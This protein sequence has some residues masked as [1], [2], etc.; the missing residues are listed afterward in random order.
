M[1]KYKQDR[2]LFFSSLWPATKESIHAF[3][4]R[5]TA[6]KK[7]KLKNKQNLGVQLADEDED[8]D[9]ENES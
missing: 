5:L 7:K 8:E 6:N 9:D 3:S 4:R 2:L 1:R